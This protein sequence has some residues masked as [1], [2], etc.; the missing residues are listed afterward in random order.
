MSPIIIEIIESKHQYFSDDITNIFLR[1]KCIPNCLSFL[2]I[3]YGIGGGNATWEI[4]DEKKM[5]Q[6]SRLLFF[7]AKREWG[8]RKNI[9]LFF[10]AAAARKD[11]KLIC[12]SFS[13]E[14]F[15]CCWLGCWCCCSCCCF[16]CSWCCCRSSFY[17][18]CCGCWCGCFIVFGENLEKN[19]LF[20][21]VA[22]CSSRQK[23]EVIATRWQCLSGLK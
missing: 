12:C 16:W 6:K 21:F 10:A 1:W 15:G 19:V 20:L 7:A 13:S 11:C 2:S 14:I 8:W 22:Q 4:S 23:L 9:N 5:L 17:W 18:C 3:F